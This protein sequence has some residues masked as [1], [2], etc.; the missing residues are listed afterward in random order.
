MTSVSLAST[1]GRQDPVREVGPLYYADQWTLAEDA[2]VTE[3]HVRRTW[4]W[5]GG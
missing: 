3:L 5:T 1:Y 2:L 4:W